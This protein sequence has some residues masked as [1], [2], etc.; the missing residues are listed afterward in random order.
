MQAQSNKHFL[1]HSACKWRQQRARGLWLRRARLKMWAC[2]TGAPLT[3]VAMLQLPRVPRRQ[4]AQRLVLPSSKCAVRGAQVDNGELAP[5]RRL[6]HQGGMPPGQQARDF[7][8]VQLDV[9][10]CLAAH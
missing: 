3:R 2:L 6:L 1:L 7:L 4:L 10:V 9:G 5:G 8:R